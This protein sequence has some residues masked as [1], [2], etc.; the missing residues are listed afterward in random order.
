MNS[1]F[2]D[3]IIAHC[4]AYPALCCSDLFKFI[5]Q[6]AFGAEHLVTDEALVLDRIVSEHASQP[7]CSAPCVEPLAFGFSR[8]NLSVLDKGLSP[9]TLARL[10]FLSAKIKG[11]GSGALSDM[12][13]ISRELILSGEIALDADVFDKE[14]D[15][16]AASG[17]PAI[18][19]SEGFREKYSPAYRV[20]ADRY[21]DFLELF[22]IIDARLCDCG[23]VTLVIEGGAGSGKSTLSDILREVYSCS[24]IHTDDYFL[25]P[26]QRT[27]QRL[28]EIGG[29][30]DRE[31]FTQ[32]VVNP[33]CANKTI[34][35][36]R[37]NCQTQTLSDVITVEKTPLTVVEGVYSM[38]EAFSEYFTLSVFLDIDDVTQKMRIL[39]RNSP[40][41]AM[42]FFDE[43]IPMENAYFDKM[44]VR[45]RCDLCISIK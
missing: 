10:F 43:W 26:E 17:Y 40:T 24:V 12:L 14:L 25:R 32:E 4:R 9:Q 45:Q 7:H 21:K 39:S 36:R 44:K 19:H 33:I 15:A 28:A 29:N 42:R 11:E 37:F 18:R 8:V 6:S 34:Q 20:I 13:K 22:L 5:Y 2:R 23:T 1:T 30:L 35:M 27:K 41:L 16:W 31:R 38:H 3:R